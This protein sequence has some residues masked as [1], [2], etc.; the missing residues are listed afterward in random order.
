MQGYYTKRSLNVNY[1]DFN[2]KSNYCIMLEKEGYYIER[3]K[4]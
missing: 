1:N 2:N 3:Y 4:K